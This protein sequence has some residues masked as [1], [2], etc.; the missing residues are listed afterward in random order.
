MSTA[1]I[2]PA[3]LSAICVAVAM[4]IFRSGRKQGEL[5]ARQ[6][7]QEYLDRAR[8]E[9]DRLYGDLVRVPDE[10]RKDDGYRRD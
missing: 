8:R 9:R 1:S 2:I 4:L 10:L 5:D 6:R 3:F 7:Q